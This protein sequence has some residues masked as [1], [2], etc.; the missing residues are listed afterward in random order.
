[1]YGDQPNRIAYTRE[2]AKEFKVDGVIGERLLFCDQWV[3]EHYMN[4]QDLK[5]DDIPFLALDREYILSG[6][7]QLRTRV[8]AFLET[9]EA[10]RN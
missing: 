3:V 7:G 10:T 2:L 1:M 8:Q 5:K 4:T 6:K 9:L